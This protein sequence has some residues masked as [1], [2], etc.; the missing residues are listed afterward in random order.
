[1]TLFPRYAPALGLA[2]AGLM[3]PSVYGLVRWL[4]RT[5]Y[6]RAL[7]TSFCGVAPHANLVLAHCPECWIGAA[8]FFAAA[9][10]FALLHQPA[11]ARR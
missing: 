4:M 3:W 11:L 2:L 8:A 9:L 10:G 6:E 7:E 1:M 5:P